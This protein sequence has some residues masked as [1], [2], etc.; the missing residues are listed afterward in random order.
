MSRPTQSRLHRQPPQMEKRSHNRVDH[1]SQLQNRP[2]HMLWISPRSLWWRRCGAARARRWH[3]TWVTTLP[4]LLQL[5]VIVSHGRFID[6]SFVYIGDGDEK[7]EASLLRVK[8]PI[9]YSFHLRSQSGDSWRTATAPHVLHFD[10]RCERFPVFCGFAHC[11]L[12]P[13]LG[14]ETAGDI[15]DCA[16][17]I[18]C[19]SAARRSHPRAQHLL[20]KINTSV[21]VPSTGA[22][23]A[24]AAAAG[25]AGQDGA[26]TSEVPAAVRARRC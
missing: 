20:T 7:V 6:V 18:C 14:R 11:G 8:P 16:V 3:A 23:D 25:A 22:E 13:L 26:G 10:P 12:R 15:E 2:P 21:A 17:L 4:S 19:Q 24:A 1:Q 9:L 5:Q